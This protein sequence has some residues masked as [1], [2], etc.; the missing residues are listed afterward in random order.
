VI[1]VEWKK[2]TPIAII[3]D[4][5]NNPR[6]NNNPNYPNSANNPNNPN[7]PYQLITPTV[8]TIQYLLAA[9]SL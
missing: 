5:L 8:L 3:N 6:H 4:K 7:N 9:L 2:A 1:G